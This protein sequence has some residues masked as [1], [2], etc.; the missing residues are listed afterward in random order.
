MVNLNKLYFLFQSVMSSNAEEEE[1]ES[2]VEFMHDV[3][4]LSN[5]SLTN[6]RKEG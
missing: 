4:C 6:D 3:E 5:K 2:V 1:E